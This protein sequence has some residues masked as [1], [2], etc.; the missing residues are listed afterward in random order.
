MQRKT[1]FLIVLIIISASFFIYFRGLK[2]KGD[3]Q[4]TT[5]QYNLKYNK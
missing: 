5:K 3:S 2:L 1:V 4:L